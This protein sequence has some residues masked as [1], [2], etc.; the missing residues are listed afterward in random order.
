M[1]NICE[2]KLYINSK[3]DPRKYCVVKNKQYEDQNEISFGKLV[4]VLENKNWSADRGCKREPETYSLKIETHWDEYILT[5]YFNTPRSPPIQWL[6]SV[7]EY[8]EDTAIVE[9]T[10]REPWLWFLWIRSNWEDNEFNTWFV[11]S[12][13]LERYIVSNKDLQELLENFGEE[14]SLLKDW[15]QAIKDSRASKEEKSLEIKLI[16]KEFKK[17]E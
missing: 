4:P 6:E 2:N 16:K 17:W 8:L 13:V 11:Y 15:I 12:E 14:P 10:Y 1:A 7:K 3:I 5:A 9:L